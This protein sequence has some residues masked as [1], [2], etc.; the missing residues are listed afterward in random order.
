MLFIVFSD[1]PGEEENT[2]Q[3]IGG[4]SSQPKE[5]VTSI[6]GIY[7]TKRAAVERQLYGWSSCIFYPEKK[8]DHGTLFKHETL[9]HNM[10]VHLSEEPKNVS[11]II[12]QI[13]DGLCNERRYIIELTKNEDIDVLMPHLYEFSKMT[14]VFD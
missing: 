13:K 9:K 10:I 11:E 4:T 6:M 7:T 8:N 3:F 12:R 14:Y 1:I 5:M 2:S